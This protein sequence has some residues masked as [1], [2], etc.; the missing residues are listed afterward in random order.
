MPDQEN[1]DVVFVIGEKPHDLFTRR[2]ND[3]FCTQNIDILTALAGGQIAI[4]YFDKQV[5]M[6]NIVP[7]EV[8]KP[9]EPI[10]L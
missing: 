8:I 9:G 10:V 3:L 2:G 4:P 1:G 6:V 5:L 7:G